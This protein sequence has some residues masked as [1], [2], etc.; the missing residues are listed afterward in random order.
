MNCTTITQ[1][2]ISYVRELGVLQWSMVELVDM[3]AWS[4]IARLLASNDQ[5]HTGYLDP[6]RCSN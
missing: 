6:G 3:F 5:L 2:R 1:E 4:G